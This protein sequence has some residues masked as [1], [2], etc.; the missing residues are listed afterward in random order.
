ML[1]LLFCMVASS[2]TRQGT[3]VGNGVT[4]DPKDD[5]NQEKIA[6]NTTTEP[7]ASAESPSGSDTGDTASNIGGGTSANTP[8]DT[9]PASNTTVPASSGASYTVATDR[10]IMAILLASCGSVFS[11]AISGKFVRVGGAAAGSELF[12]VNADALGAKTVTTDEGDR[13][14]VTAEVSQR[15]DV[16]AE[17][18]ATMT[19]PASSCQNAVT[20]QNPPGVVSPEN[21]INVSSTSVTVTT[22]GVPSKVTWYKR[23]DGSIFRIEV[24]RSNQTF[25]YEPAAQ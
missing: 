12:Q 2:C 21:S 11:E 18:A 22:A 24:V 5:K 6:S 9:A 15:I 23:A 3:E 10:E 13:F 25:T 20:V 1:A 17:D 4:V 19:L 7:P 8:M 14:V 16:K